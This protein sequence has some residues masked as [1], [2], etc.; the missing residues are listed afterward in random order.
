MSCLSVDWLSLTQQLI[1]GYAPAQKGRSRAVSFCL[2]TAVHT[3]KEGCK[4]IG[5]IS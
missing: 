5:Q 3:W 1:I 2:D 4:A